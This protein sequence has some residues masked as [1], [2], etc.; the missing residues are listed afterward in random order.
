MAARSIASPGDG[1]GG[2]GDGAGVAEGGDCDGGWGRDGIDFFRADEF[3]ERE[4][5]VR[6]L[7]EEGVVVAEGV[8]GGFAVV[9]DG[10]GLFQ[11]LA[12]FEELALVEEVGA[13]DGCAGVYEFGDGG[14]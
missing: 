10:A 6:A 12:V 3:Y 7:G 4:N 1:A 8:G 9:F 14:L 2:G 13:E 5:V 11:G